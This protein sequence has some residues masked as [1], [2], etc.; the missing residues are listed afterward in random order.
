M[1]WHSYNKILPIGSGLRKEYE[2][3][4]QLLSATHHLSQ[5]LPDE[6]AV[7]T[8]W[9]GCYGQKQVSSISHCQAEV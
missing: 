1:T 6:T 7:R 2:Y 9:D 3:A 4:K 8:K 5:I